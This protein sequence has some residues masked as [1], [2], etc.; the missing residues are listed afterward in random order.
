MNTGARR[1][2]HKCILAC[3]DVKLFQ[4]RTGREKCPEAGYPNERRSEIKEAQRLRVLIGEVVND[5]V[6]ADICSVVCTVIITIAR[7]AQILDGRRGDDF[8][9]PL[10]ES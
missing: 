9:H 8:S 7:D 3:S 6:E 10:A 4:M 2:A 1:E 5:A